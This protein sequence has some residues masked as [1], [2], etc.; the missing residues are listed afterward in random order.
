[1]RKLTVSLAAEKARDLLA[2]RDLDRVADEIRKD[3]CLPDWDLE[4]VAEMVWVACERWLVR[5]TEWMI[6]HGI[7]QRF[8]VDGES[9]VADMYG[10]FS[11]EA[12]ETLRGKTF[13][14]DWKTSSGDLD[15]RWVNRHKNSW[16]WRIYL[17][18]LN[19]DVML[20]SGIN[21]RGETR[22][23]YIHRPETLTEEVRQQLLGLDVT[24]EAYIESGL[25]IFPLAQPQACMAYGRDCEFRTDCSNWTMPRGIPGKWNWSPT[26]IDLFMLCPERWRRTNLLNAS[27]ETRQEAEFGKAFHAGIAEIYRQVWQ[28]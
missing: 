23:H 22:E 24:K 28:H 12:P 14:R 26:S 7:E 5:D 19:A 4:A 2:E 15:N 10:V 11:Q 6:L 3:N 21:R 16:Q 9:G 13:V 20:Y 8:E 18:K 1:M 27:Q 25:Q 17:N